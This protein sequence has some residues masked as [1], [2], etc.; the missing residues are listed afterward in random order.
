MCPQLESGRLEQAER[1][2]LLDVQTPIDIATLSQAFAVSE[3]KLR[4]AFQKI[5]GLP[6]CRRLRLSRVSLTRRALM[7]AGSSSVTV[8]EIAT[9]L[10]FVE[11]RRFSV[12]Y[13]EMFGERPSKNAASGSP[14][15]PWT[16]G[17]H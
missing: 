2:A 5:H 12:E 3:R 17:K 6:P 14:Q 10:G 11:L 4:K 9:G 13:R 7:S 8:S 15:W 1:L 16:R